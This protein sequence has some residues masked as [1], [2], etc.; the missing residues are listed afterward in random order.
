[1]PDGSKGW[2]NGGSYLEFPAE[3]RGKTREVTLKGE[4]YFEVKENLKR[5][6][7]VSGADFEVLV[8]GT[9]FNVLAYPG[10][11]DVKVTLASGSVEVLCK[12]DEQVVQSGSL[13]PDQMF[14]YNRQSSYARI[15]KVNASKVIA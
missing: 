13:S 6:F 3:F 9:T 4:A 12:R 2:L 8:H 14:I 15:E 1:L 5:P 10:D 7:I 11:N